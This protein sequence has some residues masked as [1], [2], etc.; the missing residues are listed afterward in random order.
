MKN[1]KQLKQQTQFFHAILAFLMKYHTVKEQS[2]LSLIL[3]LKIAVFFTV[4]KAG[5][6]LC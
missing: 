4:A 5:M 6:G 1:L 2:V 3:V